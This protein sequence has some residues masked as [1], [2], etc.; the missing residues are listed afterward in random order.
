MASTAD[1]SAPVNGG[2]RPEPPLQQVVAERDRLR[3]ELDEARREILQLK[4]QAEALRQEWFTA[5]AQEEEY[6][7]Y[8]KKLTGLDPYISPQEILEAEKNGYTGQQI[9]EEIAKG[10]KASGR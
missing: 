7:R 8:I 1:P 5:K 10:V 2:A 6:R 3:L 4:C 9:F